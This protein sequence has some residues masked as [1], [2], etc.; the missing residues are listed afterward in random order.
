M[1]YADNEQVCESK[2]IVHYAP[3]PRV[4]AACAVEQPLLISQDS[5]R[6]TCSYCLAKLQL[7]VELQLEL[8]RR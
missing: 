3:W 6:V 4:E 2:V 1:L 8:V 7:A 5:R